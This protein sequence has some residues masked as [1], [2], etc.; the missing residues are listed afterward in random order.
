MQNSEPWKRG[1]AVEDGIE[2][3]QVEHAEPD[4]HRRPDCDPRLAVAAIDSP[5]EEDLPI[6]VDLDVMHEME[7]HALSNRSI[8]LGGVL[9]GGQYV[10]DQGVPFVVI[11][12]CIRA[13]HYQATKGSFKFTHETWESISRQREEFPPELKMVGWYHTHPGWGIFLSGMDMF[14]CENFFNRPLDVALVIDPCQGHRGMFQWTA[15]QQVRQTNGF[16]L[17]ATRFRADELDTYASRLQKEPVMMSPPYPAPPQRDPWSDPRAVVAAVILMAM[18]TMQFAVLAV[19]AW[20]ML[21]PADDRL[22]AAVATLSKQLDSN[23][24]QQDLLAQ[25]RL[26]DRVVASLSK[27]GGG[28]LVSELQE[29]QQQLD[30]AQAALRGQ[31]ALREKNELQLLAANDE[32]ERLQRQVES[33]ESMLR[34]EL[35]RS[36]TLAQRLADLDPDAPAGDMAGGALADKE[37][38]GWR[39]WHYALAVIGVVGVAA[40]IVALS[41]R[42]ADAPP[43]FDNLEEVE[44]APSN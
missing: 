44:Q 8:E 9:L 17:T 28:S 14:I 20:K 35:K 40:F 43:R 24:Q 18:L 19:I 4:K 5:Q 41:R 2:F 1:G 21:Q 7:S 22:A 10:D 23:D 36:E 16:Y 27:D 42:G 25:Q 33:K 30:A 31:D 11:N 6:F 3:G 32:A 34:R 13:Q 15:D 39:W 29:K 37:A 26:L 12:E 38:E